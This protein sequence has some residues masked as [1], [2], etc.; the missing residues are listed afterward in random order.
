MKSRLAL[1]GVT[2]LAWSM[3]AARLPAQGA[4]E[5]LKVIPD[6]ALG[7]AVVRNLGDSNAK[8]LAL[9]KLVNAPLPGDPL[10]L[11]KMALGVDKGFDEKGSLLTVVLAENDEPVPVVLLPVTDYKEFVTPLKPKKTDGTI[12]EAEVGN[13]TMLVARKGNYA[14]FADPKGRAALQKLLAAKKDV[15]AATAPLQTWLG[16]SDA[17]LVVTGSGVKLACTRMRDALKQFRANLRAVLGPQAEMVTAQLDAADGLLKSA[18]TDVTHVALGATIDPKRN[19]TVNL[20]ALFAKGSG[21]AKRAAEIAP[22]AGGSLAGLPAGPFAIAGG[23][24]YPEGAAEALMSF[25]AQMIKATAPDLSK[26]NAQKLEQAYVQMAKGMRGTTLLMGVGKAKE[27]FLSSIVGVMKVDDAATYLASYEKGLKDLNDVLKD[28]RQAA[29]SVKKVD[30]GGAAG[31][32]VAVDLAADAPGLPKQLIELLAGE[33]G[34]MTVTM[35]AVDAKTIVYRYSGADGLK[36]FMQVYKA[37]KAALA[38][39]TDVAKTTALLPAGAQWAWYVS[40][41]GTLDVAGRLAGAVGVP[42][43]LPPFP[44][45]PPVALAFKLSAAGLEGQLAIPAG[46]FEGIGDLTRKLGQ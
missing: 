44:K 46:V 18:E 4:T 9:A 5:F 1:I 2:M 36:E 31:L 6:E 32:E 21:F 33:G 39:D 43:A 10:A 27:P 25:S 7:F 38:A 12:T 37:K 30:V 20:Q 3:S 11:V 15:S 23:G 29:P 17:A 42:L 16:N 8:V 45:T 14:A 35:A 19:I 24:P 28:A 26:E 41:Q 34:K 22:L 40:P 13:D